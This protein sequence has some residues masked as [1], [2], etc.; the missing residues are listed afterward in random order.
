MLH[1]PVPGHGP[2]VTVEFM[3]QAGKTIAIATMPLDAVRA[4]GPC[5]MAHVREIADAAE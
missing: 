3:T 1:A 2:G 4:I 5:D